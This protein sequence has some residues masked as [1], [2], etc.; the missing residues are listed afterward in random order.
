L[1]LSASGYTRNIYNN[2]YC[3]I[4]LNEKV[5]NITNKF[6][7]FYFDPQRNYFLQVEIPVKDRNYENALLDNPLLQNFTL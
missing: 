5:D 1:E 4:F 7:E 2:P 6:K 3:S